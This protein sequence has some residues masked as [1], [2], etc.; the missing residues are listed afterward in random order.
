MSKQKHCEGISTNSTEAELSASYLGFDVAPGTNSVQDQ[1]DLLNLPPEIRNMIYTMVIADIK[2]CP[3]RYYY[4]DMDYCPVS[5]LTLRQPALASVNRQLRC[6]VLAMWYTGKTFAS[7]RICPK[8]PPGADQAWLDLLDRFTSRTAGEHVSHYPSPI[9]SIVVDLR[10]PGLDP[11][12]RGRRLLQQT[13]AVSLSVSHDASHRSGVQDV[14]YLH[15]VGDE[16]TDWADRD[17]VRSVLWG[18]IVAEHA[19]RYAWP[20]ECYWE[21]YPL[22]RLVDLV[23]M[24]AAECK[25]ACRLVYMTTSLSALSSA[26]SVSL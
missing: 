5:E 17:A 9:Q 6:E 26:S 16:N 13:G 3:D 20:L 7:V 8:V 14:P 10:H 23:M 24:V 2:Y 22:E 18:S 11:V 4:P 19:V 12:G 21:M 25:E 15:R 1:T